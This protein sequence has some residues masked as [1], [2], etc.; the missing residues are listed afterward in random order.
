[1]FID[2]LFE[3]DIVLLNKYLN[4]MAR[5]RK[6][7]P[8]NRAKKNDIIVKNVKKTGDHPVKVEDSDHDQHEARG[9]LPQVK[10]CKEKVEIKLD[11]KNPEK[12]KKE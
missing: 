3:S 8:H 6:N 9:N 12:D 7:K 2:Y 1:M 4:I 10:G 5:T 11:P